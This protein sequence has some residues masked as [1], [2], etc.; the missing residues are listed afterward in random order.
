M[1]SSGSVVSCPS[2]AISG[3]SSTQIHSI[4]GYRSRGSVSPVGDI[5]QLD[6]ISFL[7][8]HLY[9]T[10]SQAVADT[11]I[12]GFRDSSLKQQEMAWRAFQQWLPQCTVEVTLTTILQFLFTLFTDTE[13]THSTIN[14]Y[15]TSLSC[16]STSN[17]A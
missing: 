1:G 14:S 12:A 5:R 6:R 2:A 16:S 3:S 4:P 11:I 17:L 8:K 7:R 13:L 10:H 9:K 15:K